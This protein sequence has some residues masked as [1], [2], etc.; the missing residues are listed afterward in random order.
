ML[1][2]D[3][4]VVPRQLKMR[5]RG[6][7]GITAFYRSVVDDSTDHPEV[8]PA[9]KNRRC[10]CPVLSTEKSRAVR[11]DALNRSTTAQKR[12]KPPSLGD[13]GFSLSRGDRI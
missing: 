13:S 10:R 4:Q 11:A 5:C 9:T 6:R 1:T 8:E 2:T 3:G 7:L 12:K